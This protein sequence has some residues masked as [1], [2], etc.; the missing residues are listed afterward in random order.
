MNID[1]A[2]NSAIQV[3]GIALF[4]GL[5]FFVLIVIM[6]FSFLSWMDLTK[7]AFEHMA[8]MSTRIVN[9]LERSEAAAL[10]SNSNKSN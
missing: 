9:A 5:M 2:I 7:Q 8:K 1:P 3:G 6:I 4:I 10:S